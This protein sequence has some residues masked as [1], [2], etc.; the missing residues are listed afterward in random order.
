MGRKFTI[1]ALFNFVFK[2][3]FQE[4]APPGGLYSE[5][6]FNGGRYDFG[7]LVFGGVYFRNFTVFRLRYYRSNM[8][9]LTLKHAFKGH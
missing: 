2:G 4:Q 3:K 7:G 8:V 6:R 1:F 9:P 5:G